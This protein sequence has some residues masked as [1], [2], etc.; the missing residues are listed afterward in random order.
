MPSS[1][2]DESFVITR[3]CIKPSTPCPTPPSRNKKSV[4]S[5]LAA[6]GTRQI[7]PNYFLLQT[8]TI[9]IR[10]Q[11]QFRRNRRV[12]SVTPRLTILVSKDSAD[13]KIGWCVH[14]NRVPKY[15]FL[16]VLAEIFEYEKTKRGI[17]FNQQFSMI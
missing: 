15:Q 17:A 10:F 14:L 12:M 7:P 4:P 13:S 5:P 11:A 2:G 3:A 8:K 16:Y 9:A 1:D 6:T